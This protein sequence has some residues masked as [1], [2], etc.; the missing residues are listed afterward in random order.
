MRRA[1]GARRLSARTLCRIAPRST[2]AQVRPGI[3]SPDPSRVM[4]LAA[5]SR[6]GSASASFISEAGVEDVEGE[7]V[8]AGN[9]TYQPIA[10]DDGQNFSALL[11]HD[12]RGL[13][14]GR[15]WRNGVHVLC[16]DLADGDAGAFEGL[17]TILLRAPERYDATQDVEEARRLDVRVLKDEVAL[18]DY[19]EKPPVAY[20]RRAGDPSLSEELDGR[21]DGA[22]GSQG[23]PIGLHNLRDSKLPDVLLIH[24]SRPSS[25]YDRSR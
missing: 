11:G 21:L 18:G 12:G 5:G 9:D 22:P 24:A 19:P 3:R 20:D 4:L 6:K 25:L 8:H 23:R 15:L 16:H 1:S 13:G 7:G 10:F 2:S 17:P 14:K